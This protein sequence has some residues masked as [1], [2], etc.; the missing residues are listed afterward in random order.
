V[1]SPIAG[2]NRAEIEGLIGFFVNTLVLRTD[3]SGDPTFRELLRRVREAALGAYAHQDLPFEKLVEEL[4]PERDVRQ[5][6]LVQVLFALQNAPA[7]DLALPE[8]TLARF[9]VE[10]QASRFDLELYAWEGDTSLQASIVYATDLFDATTIERLANHFREL[11]HAVAADPDRKIEDVSLLS[12]AERHRS[13]VEWNRTQTDYPRDATVPTLFEQQAATTPDADALVS[14][15]DRMSYRELN[16][17]AN[18]LAGLLRERGAGPGSLVGLAMDRSFEMVVGILG[19]LKS[20]AAYVPLD[21]GYPPARLA[22]MLDDTGSR[23]VVTR[24]SLREILPPGA[25]EVV[26]LDG[27]SAEIARQPAANPT[28]RSSAEDLAYVMYTSGSTGTPKGVSVRHRGIVRLVRNTDYVELSAR[29]VLLQ[30]APISFDAS[31]F[32]IW[33]ALLNGGTLVLGPPGAASLEEL[34]AVIR[35]HGVTTLWLTAGLFHQMVDRQLDG[36]RGVRQ[37]LAGGDVLSPSRVERVLRELPDCRLI[38]GYGPTENTTFT[39]CHTI[40]PG[41]L[42]GANVPI[43]RPIANTCVFLL[44]RRQRPV[45]I[46]LPGELYAGGDGLAR[47]YW[48][49]PVRTAERFVP[50][51]FPEVPAAGERLYRTGDRARYRPDGAIEFLGRLDEQV[52]VRGYRVEPAEVEA[53]LS[54]HPGVAA[55]AVV[56][57]EDSRGEKILVAY[58][59]PAETAEESGRVGHGDGDRQHEQVAHW[60]DLYEDLYSPAASP[61]PTFDIVGWNSSYTGQPLPAE[62]MR[63]WL[64]ATVE[65]I[66]SLAPK[67]ALEIGCGTGLVLFRVAPVASAYTATDFSPRAL[68]QLD[69]ALRSPEHRIEGVRLLHRTADDFEELEAR[70]FDTVILNSVVQYFPGVSYLSRVLEGAVECTAD[71]GS[72]FLGDVRSLP[73]LEHLHLSLELDR[74]PA[75]LPLD[76]LRRRVRR[77]M[78]AE[79]ELVVDPTFFLAFA[80]RNPRITGVRVLPKFGRRDNELN[81]YRYDVILRIGQGADAPETVEA[82]DWAGPVDPGPVS[83]SLER[84]RPRALRVAGIANA[85]LS[86]ENRALERMADADAPRTAGELRAAIAALPPDGVHPEELKNWISGLPYRVEPSWSSARSSGEYDALFVRADEGP[87]V[88]GKI[89]TGADAP[90]GAYTNNPLRALVSRRL[91]P[92]LRAFLRQALPESLVPSAFVVLDA[93]PLTPSGKLDRKAL[94]PPDSE[95]TVDRG[96]FVEPR[97]PIEEVLAGIWSQVLGVERVGSEDDFFELGG[98]SL[99]ATQVVSRIREAFGVELPLRE[100][101]N[102]PTV[103]ALARTLTSASPD[104]DVADAPLV[105]VSR[106]R[107]LPLSFAQQRLWFLDQLEP[108]SAFYATTRVLR[109]VGS[110]DTGALESAFSRVIERHESLRT[111]FRSIEGRPVQVVLPRCAFRVPLVDLTSVPEG[112]REAAAARRAKEEGSRPFDLATAPLLR[113]CLL[114]LSKRE[115]VLVIAMHHIVS[116]GWSLGILVQELAA[117]YEEARGGRPAALPELSIQYPDFAAWQR[118]WLTGD[119]LESQIS[120][121]RSQLSGLPALELPTDRP[122]PAV[123]SYRG[124]RHS[125]VFPRPLLEAARDLARREG[126]TLYMTLLAA[127]AAVLQRYTGQD[128]VAVGSPIAGRNR[129]EIEGLIGFFVNTL[130]LRTD[131]SGDPTFR[132]LLRRVREAALGAYAHQ[133][134]PFEKLVEELQPERDLAR[135]PLFQ[136][137][138]ALQNAPGGSFELSGLRVSPFRF[139]SGTA[140]FDLEVHLWDRPEGLVC[141]LLYAT[142]L[143]D[144]ETAARMAGHFQVLLEAAVADPRSRVSELPLLTEPE[145]Q[146][147]LMGWNRTDAPY[148]REATLVS[149][150][151]DQAA[152]TP[153]A[154]AVVD[155]PRRWTYRDLNERANRVARALARRGIGAEAP[156][157]LCVD[158]S[159]EMVVGLLGILKA[160]GAYVP[161][162]PEYPRE[163]LAFMLEDSGARALVSVDRLRER[164]PEGTIERIL[165][166]ADASAIARESGENRPPSAGPRNLA[167]VIYT[168]GS[169]GRPKGV[170]I[171]HGNAVA[172]VAWAHGVF[173]ARDL[174]GTLASTSICFDLSVFELFAPLTS[175][176]RV[177]LAENVLALPD[178]PS[179]AE[180]RLV[181]TV[182]SAIAELVR[183]SSLPP[184]VST[185]NLAGEPLPPSLVGEVL[186]GGGVERVFDLYGPTEDTTYS[187]CA[188]RLPDAPPTIGRPIANKRAYILDPHRRPVPV[189]VAGDLY[190]AGAGV[191]R[192]YLNRPELTAEKFLP[193]PFR[194]DGSRMYRTGDRARWLASGEIQFLGRLDEQVK[195]RGYRIEIGEIEETLARHR[196]VRACAVA[197]K[198]LAPGDRR[199]V[200]Y[201]VGTDPPPSAGELRDFLKGTLPE[202]MVPSAFVFLDSLPRTPNGKVDRRALPEPGQARPEVSGTFVEPGTEVE[203]EIAEIWRNVL[204]LERVGIH[205]NFFELGGH[206]LLATLVFARLQRSFSADLSLRTLFDRPTIAELARAIATA[207]RAPST[208]ARPVIP[209]LTRTATARPPAAEEGPEIP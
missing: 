118:E 136:V 5:N 117:F 23:L 112:E 71:E 125:V 102:A 84:E 167:Y 40:R 65:R 15:E 146:Q 26:T 182:P 156:V 37:L 85:R 73:L 172:L 158:R 89:P 80:R 96:A 207:G 60:R 33:G 25:R 74:A 30:F 63:E 188:R 79:E 9:E 101:F 67:R 105:A 50:N 169:T 7:A 122:R 106:E 44:D 59:V 110:L 58:V 52:K 190:V 152:R 128:D 149:L 54:R 151:E 131:V 139:E 1:G 203:R 36:L 70:R 34:S 24:E 97:N 91:V 200:G 121:W 205:D 153:D 8:A 104:A 109:V 178:L 145:R 193:D 103:A 127:F 78:L 170:A 192:G 176:G 10:S 6:P 130:V 41:T 94:P 168:S 57:R 124:G 17:R 108:G 76:E 62:D 66:L 148:P 173:G 111:R 202:P 51:P 183:T 143:F 49:D 82:I 92:V 138:F 69:R 114:R 48:N 137:L 177:L 199:L 191:A 21:T 119:R 165:L 22:W 38:N 100:V 18:R 31:T 19:I 164:L 35:R 123:Q 129:A 175:G 116:D 180:V 55:S 87:R 107:E 46:G 12:D 155:G 132:E 75:S 195:I 206:S 11:L 90:L 154:Q 99:L 20:G 81:R 98:H 32:E 120:Y 157:G 61:D 45:P 56:A 150:F 174:A 88:A 126:A 27:D 161:L 204:R 135:N 47:D 2:R 198:E 77:G 209:P 93:L 196:A 4:Q 194:A 142:D 86:R 133:D 29:E 72:I 64:E 140:R 186:A 171:E 141:T 208:G 187:T 189:G 179:A 163:R 13:V 201:V 147:V 28:P 185:V 115:H 160:G 184:G 39:C 144:P 14:G 134:L 3:V 43:G 197:V 113:V 166:D 53:A 95:T 83:R 68:A 159:L 42:S 162:D 181:N 16:E